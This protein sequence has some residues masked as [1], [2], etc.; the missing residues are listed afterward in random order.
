MVYQISIVPKAYNGTKM[1]ISIL[2]SSQSTLQDLGH[3]LHSSLEV[4]YINPL[5]VDL[6][7]YRTHTRWKIEK[8]MC[9][10]T[11]PLSKILVIACI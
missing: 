3:C 2:V 5:N 7:W 8:P 6:N 11:N 1:I 10:S 4:G 9:S